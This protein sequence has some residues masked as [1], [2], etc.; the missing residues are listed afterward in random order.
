MMT[1]DKVTNGTNRRRD[2]KDTIYLKKMVMR[3]EEAN[4]QRNGEVS[5]TQ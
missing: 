1:F 2:G 3:E 4:D 5:A